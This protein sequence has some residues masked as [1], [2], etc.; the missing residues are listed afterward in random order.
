MP[1]IYDV[2]F[3]LFGV[4]MLP[5]DKRYNKLVRFVQS[6]L[7]PAQWLRDLY[8]GSYRTG[9]TASAWSNGATYAKYAQVKFN[10]Q[11][12]Q[13]LEDGNIG[14]TPSNSPTKWALVQENFIGVSERILYGGQKLTLEYA[15]NKW[16]GTVF[17]QP[18]LVSDI[19]IG[20][21]VIPVPAFIVG[22]TEPFSSTVGRTI[23]SEYIGPT[24]VLTVTSN[25]TIYVPEAVYNAL[26]PD[27]INNERIFRSFADR[28]VPAGLTYNIETY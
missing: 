9:S 11:V 13:S 1:T 15:L 7:T 5:T 25:F 17:R 10:K 20:T 23:S 3:D 12:Y 14:N 22:D 6:L 19:Y 18:N 26:D 4:Q 2:N 8:G 24:P 27:M 21:N 16:F 28:Y